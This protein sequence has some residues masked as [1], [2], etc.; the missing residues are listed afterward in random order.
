MVKKVLGKK[1]SGCQYYLHDRVPDNVILEDKEVRVRAKSVY[2]QL[3][4][5]EGT[6]SFEAVEGRFRVALGRATFALHYK[7]IK[8]N[9][10]SALSKRK[11]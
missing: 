8:H 6:D 4:F 7:R 5:W 9:F 2:K 3:R 10:N 1:P 11:K